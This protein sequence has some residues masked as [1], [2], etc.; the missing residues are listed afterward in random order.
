MKK[1][2]LSIFAVVATVLMSI[3]VKGQSSHTG[4]A[5][6]EIISNTSIVDNGSGSGSYLSF[7]TLQISQT[8]GGTCT[9]ST[10]AKS[11][12]TG[13]VSLVN[14]VISAGNALFGIT[15][16][17]GAIYVINLPGTATVIRT[18]GTETMTIENFT[19]RPA[20]AGNDQTTGIFNLSTG[21]DSFTV[22][23]TLKV[24]ANQAVGVYTGTFDVSVAYN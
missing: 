8:E 24:S 12:V 1:I 4:S 10:T 22:G 13:G 17:A 7:G 21:D 2:V 3:C 18:G 16:L 20:S 19:V 5:F 9:V 6:A 11:S 14:K 23:G 15:G